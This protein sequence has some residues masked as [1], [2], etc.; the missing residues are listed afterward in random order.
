M[1]P[2]VLFQR[3]R[4][5]AAP[6][7]EVRAPKAPGV[8]AWFLGEL[9][10]VPA[11][12]DEGGEAV[13]VGIPSNLARRGDDDDFRAGGSGFSTLR[14]SLG[15]LLKDELRLRAL[16]RS[17]GRSEQNYRCYRFDDAGE[18][19]LTDWMRRYLRIGV[20]EHPNPKQVESSLIAIA[21]PPLNLTGWPN[22]HA[23]ALRAGRKRCADEA[24]GRAE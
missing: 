9:V 20:A 2:A 11:L 24:R 18:R 21:H 7:D 15:A 19:R 8:Y 1:E 6:I 23:P 5:C 22:P 17:S 12:P 3:L 14:R 4:E 16:P 13:Y 10:A